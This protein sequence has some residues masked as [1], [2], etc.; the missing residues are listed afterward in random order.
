M[1]DIVFP[2]IDMSLD[3]KSEAVQGASSSSLHHPSV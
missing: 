1:Y 2:S 3:S